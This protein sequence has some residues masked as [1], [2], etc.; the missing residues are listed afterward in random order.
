MV[1][2]MLVRIKGAMKRDEKYARFAP[3]KLRTP[4]FGVP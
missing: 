2:V 4:E 1:C 3:W